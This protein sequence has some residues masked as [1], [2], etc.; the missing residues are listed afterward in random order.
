MGDQPELLEQV[1]R[2]VNGGQTQAG[3]HLPDALGDRLRRGVAEVGDRLQHQLAL[4]R[5]PVSARAERTVP[6]RRR[7]KYTV[8]RASGMAPA[9]PRIERRGLQ[10]VLRLLAYNGEAWLAE[11]FNAY[12]ADPDEHRAILLQLGGRVD[13]Q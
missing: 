12:L 7:H 3:G 2:A 6:S 13:Y 9:R 11:H 8:R 1:Q 10:M 5:Q 4:R